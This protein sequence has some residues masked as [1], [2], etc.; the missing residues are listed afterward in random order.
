V[1]KDFAQARDQ[2]LNLP[3]LSPLACNSHLSERVIQ[4][5]LIIL[6]SRIN[7]ADT[8]DEISGFTQISQ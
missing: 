7:F 6:E 5:N 8:D 4:D 1:V 2:T 3:V